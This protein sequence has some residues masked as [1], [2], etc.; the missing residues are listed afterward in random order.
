[1]WTT[2]AH[3]QCIN[4]DFLNYSCQEVDCQPTPNLLC[5]ST[6]LHTYLMLSVAY[7]K[8][9]AN[10]QSHSII[11]YSTVWGEKEVG[12]KSNHKNTV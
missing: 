3:I 11:H 7:T 12:N 10:P 5:F 8:E 4:Y 9:T 6:N 1:M 2:V